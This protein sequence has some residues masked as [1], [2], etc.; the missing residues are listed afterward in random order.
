MNFT[1]FLGNLEPCWLK[2]SVLKPIILT[3]IITI[4]LY[5]KYLKLQDCG[6]PMESDRQLYL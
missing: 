3:Q 6:V 5:L 1:L 4:L 2:I